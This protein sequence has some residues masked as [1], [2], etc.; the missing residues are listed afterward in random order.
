MTNNSELSWP[1]ALNDGK[2]EGGPGTLHRLMA[3]NKN[4]FESA[5]LFRNIHVAFPDISGFGLKILQY[6]TRYGR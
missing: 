2:S 6:G 4:F 5:F 1:N 3:A